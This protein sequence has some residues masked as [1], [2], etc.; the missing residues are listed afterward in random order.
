M[1]LVQLPHSLYIKVKTYICSCG[2]KR[3]DSK[4]VLAQRALYFTLLS[5]LRRI[6]G[7]KIPLNYTTFSACTNENEV[8]TESSCLKWP[9]NTSFFVF[10]FRTCS[11]AWLLW[12]GITLIPPLLTEFNFLLI[13][14]LFSFSFS[15]LSSYSQQQWNFSDSKVSVVA[16]V[17]KLW[18]KR[19]HAKPRW[20]YAPK[21][22]RLHNQATKGKFGDGD[23]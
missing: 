18:I 12:P 6:L 20:K 8:E 13:F 2:N 9:L 14:V 17:A 3:K 11:P 10:N 21:I 15:S 4:W 1:T 16:D 19:S 22:P 5:G 23:H 7:P